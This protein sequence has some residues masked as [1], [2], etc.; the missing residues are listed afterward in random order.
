[1]V[2]GSP[3]AKSNG[4]VG[5]KKSAGASKSYRGNAHTLAGPW[6]NCP[7]ILM[8]GKRKQSNTLETRNKNPIA[9]VQKA[10]IQDRTYIFKIN[11]IALR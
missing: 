9:F 10:A 1:M 2:P 3:T 4:Q 7:K 6:L 11:N 5:I 8:F